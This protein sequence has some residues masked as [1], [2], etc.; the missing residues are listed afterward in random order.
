MNIN[1]NSDESYNGFGA[2]PLSKSANK[3]SSTKI[4]SLNVS[5]SEI[6]FWLSFVWYFAKIG[7]SFLNNLG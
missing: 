6:K 2:I 5:N 7:L 1:S 4:Y 3:S